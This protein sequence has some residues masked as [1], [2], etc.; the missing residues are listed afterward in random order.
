MRRG[1]EDVACLGVD[2]GTGR[3]AGSGRDTR[4][5]PAVHVHQ[6]DLIERVPGLA[7][8]LEDELPAVLRPVALAGA[9]SFD[10]QTADPRQEIALRR[11]RLCRK[12][13][14]GDGKKNE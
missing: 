14:C 4:R 9:A 6:I 5:V 8:A 3:L 11:L 12:G 1:E 10:R 7:L 13:R 2:K